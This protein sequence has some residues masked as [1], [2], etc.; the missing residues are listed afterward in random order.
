MIRVSDLVSDLDCVEEDGQFHDSQQEAEDR[1]SAPQ[2]ESAT[3]EQGDCAVFDIETAPL[4]DDVLM[5]LIEPFVPPPH[6]GEFNPDSVKY[7]NAKKPEKRQEIFDLAAEKHR[8]DI[9]KYADNVAQA[10]AAWIPDNL[11]KIK[12]KA[13]LDATTGR[14]VAIGISPNTTFGDGPEIVDCDGELECLG[15]KTFWR[16]VEQCLA[17][18]RPML[19][20]NIYKFDLPFLCQRSWILGVSVPLGVRHGRGWNPLLLDTAVAW[21]FGAYG[22]YIGLDDLAHAFGIKG[23]A[24]GQFTLPSNEVVLIDGANF[25]KAWRREDCRTLAEEYL[26]A[27]LRIPAEIGRRMGVV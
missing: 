25:Y 10:E 20:H 8:L 5:A 14:V 11:A 4:D 7:G 3:D 16:W 13:A 1:D 6:P 21:T 22:Q 17:A 24:K 9:E 26:L 27:D 15:L 18:G 23:K 19:G 12:E 2:H